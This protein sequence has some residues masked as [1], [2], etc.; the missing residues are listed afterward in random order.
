MSTRN[1]IQNRFP[2]SGNLITP[3]E[4]AGW[5]LSLRTEAAGW[6]RRSLPYHA[7]RR[8]D[9]VRV[10]AH[11]HRIIEL[12]TLIHRGQKFDGTLPHVP[13]CIEIV[14]DVDSLVVAPRDV[15]P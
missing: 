6:L 15:V 3:H 14:H 2:K 4:A 12:L 9:A 1:S 5:R 7:L 10:S 8:D 11:R 13:E